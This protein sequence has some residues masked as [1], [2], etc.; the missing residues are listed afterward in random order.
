MSSIIMPVWNIRYWAWYSPCTAPSR[1]Y[2]RAL[3]LVLLQRQQTHLGPADSPQPDS[4]LLH[5]SAQLSVVR[6]FR[7]LSIP[8]SLPAL[9]PLSMIMIY[10]PLPG[11]LF[12]NSGLLSQLKR[13]TAKATYR[14]FA[15]ILQIICS[16]KRRYKE[17]LVS[18][19]LLGK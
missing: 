6:F 17:S 1:Q 13:M 3:S 12:E 7:S 2:T 10:T 15:C 14:M 5:R 9:C 4:V 16:S 19:S 8:A 18:L 11:H